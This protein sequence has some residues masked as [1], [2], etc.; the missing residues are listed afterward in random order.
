MVRIHHKIG[1]VIGVTLMAVLLF[2]ATVFAEGELPDS[3]EP[4][5]TESGVEST[6]NESG[7]E[8]EPAPT[9]AVEA[10][11]DLSEGLAIEIAQQQLDETEP[12]QPS[13]TEEIVLVDQSGNVM[14]MASQESA[15][16]FQGGDPWWISGGVKYAVVFTDQFC[17]LGTSED[18]GTCW[19][20]TENAISTALEKIDALNLLPTNGMLVVENGN[21]VE[22]NLVIDGLDGNGV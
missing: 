12:T 4:A 20:V 14:D 2:S 7:G 21:Y 5:S 8:S 19:K 6:A 10:P 9:N 17:P 11:E 16:A 22:N 1:W 18:A 13:T 15:E 3:Q